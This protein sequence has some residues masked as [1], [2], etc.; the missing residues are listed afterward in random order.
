M[1][2]W[3]LAFG[4]IISCAGPAVRRVYRGS[5]YVVTCSTVLDLRLIKSGKINQN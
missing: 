4:L 5:R 3:E 1:T 2:S